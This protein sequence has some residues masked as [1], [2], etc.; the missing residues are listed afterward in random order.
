MG[1][2]VEKDIVIKRVDPSNTH[3]NTIDPINKNNN[4][5]IKKVDDRRYKLIISP[6]LEKGFIQ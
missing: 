1:H 4:I 5:K 3:F 6:F 2:I